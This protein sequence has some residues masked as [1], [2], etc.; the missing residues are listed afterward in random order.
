M[1]QK[2]KFN[3]P[4]LSINDQINLLESRGLHIEDKN[5][6]YKVFYLMLTT[7]ISKDIGT[8]STIKTNKAISSIIMFVSRR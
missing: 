5:I 7:I 1:M 6:A 8:H 3:K 4:A 2:K